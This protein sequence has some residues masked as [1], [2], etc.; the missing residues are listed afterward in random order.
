[1]SDH[2]CSY[3]LF[4]IV[5]IHVGLMAMEY[6]TL[7]DSAVMSVVLESDHPANTTI[8]VILQL[9]TNT[10]SGTVANG[11]FIFAYFILILFTRNGF[12]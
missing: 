7:E 8:T 1:M 4:I 9:T 12:Q 6:F 5:A 11:I 3:I 10:A 2:I